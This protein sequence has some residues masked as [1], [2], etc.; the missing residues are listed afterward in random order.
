MTTKTETVSVWLTAWKV[1]EGSRAE[2]FPLHSLAYDRLNSTMESQGWVKVGT[3]EITV[4]YL[5]ADDRRE[6]AADAI[7]AQMADAAAKYQAMQT[8]LQERL[9]KL[10]AIGCEVEQ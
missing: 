6:K 5:P 3:A 1:E 7:R 2:Q 9:N 4:T 10:L 8:E